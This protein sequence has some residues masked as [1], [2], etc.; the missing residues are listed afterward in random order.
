MK[1]LLGGFI[2]G[3]LIGAGTAYAGITIYEYK[4]DIPCS[5]V[6]MPY[7]PPI[8]GDVNG[9]GVVDMQDLDIIA[10]NFNTSPPADERADINKDGI[11][12]IYDLVIVGK[13]FGITWDD[14]ST[15]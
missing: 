6:V 4:A 1:G 9:D 8:E 7:I 13:N 10:Q 5:V 15:G 2:I 3:L 11:V 12:D 14:G